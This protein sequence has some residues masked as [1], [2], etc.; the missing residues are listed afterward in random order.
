MSADEVTGWTREELRQS[1]QDHPED[2]DLEFHEYYCL[3]EIRRQPD[4]YYGEQRYCSKYTSLGGE[5]EDRRPRCRFHDGSSDTPEGQK[6]QP[7]EALAIKHG[8]YAEDANLIED[9]SEA[10]EALFE[11]IMS[12]AEEYGFEEGSP[13]HV[14]LESLALSK[15]REMRGEVYL[16]EN[17]EIV[18]EESFDP[19]TGQKTER[20]ETHPLKNDLRLQKQTIDKML[21][22]L[23]LTPKAE[24]QMDLNDSGASAA[25]AVGEMAQNAIDSEGGGY[26]PDQF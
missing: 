26:D 9:F 13:A 6:V 2:H 12:W 8:M 1:I 5:G 10:D 14:Q 17:G 24:S 11:Q 25:E 21:G 19:E 18:L 23:G 3:G 20:E 7:G 22:S 4:D 16:Q 15:V